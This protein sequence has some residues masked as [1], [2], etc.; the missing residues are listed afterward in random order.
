MRIIFIKISISDDTSC[1]FVA[2][3]ARKIRISFKSQPNSN[4]LSGSFLG[5]LSGRVPRYMSIQWR[6]GHC[7]KCLALML[8]PYVMLGSGLG[9]LAAEVSAS[10]TRMSRLSHNSSGHD[11][12]VFKMTPNWIFHLSCEFHFM[13]SY[14]F[15]LY[16]KL[17][18]FRRQGY[19]CLVV[20]LMSYLCTCE[21]HGCLSDHPTDP[22]EVLG[23][24][25]PRHQ[26]YLKPG[27]AARAKGVGWGRWTGVH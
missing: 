23:T 6:G 9:P 25:T 5:E 2:T 14:V 16:Q 27:I 19:L 21:S 20:M 17:L 15:I 22:S 8:K 3:Q 7:G 11:V 4:Q 10:S 1:S 12:L 13:W 24:F 18:N 26:S